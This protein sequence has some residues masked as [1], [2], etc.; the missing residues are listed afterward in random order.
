MRLL[1]A[2]YKPF[3]AL[4]NALTAEGCHLLRWIPGSRPLPAPNVDGV[5]VDFCAAARNLVAT[6]GLRRLVGDGVPII[7]INRDAPWHKGVRRRRLWGLRQLRLL[8]IYAS[9]SMQEAVRFAPRQLYLPNAAQ[10]EVYNL[11]ESTLEELRD[12]SRYR[13]PVTFL[14]NLD[15]QRYREHQPRV[16][17]LE[18]LR[19]R[20][21]GLGIALTLIHSME[22]S[23]AQ[24]AEVIRGSRINLNYG[25]ACDHGEQRTWGL[26]ERCYGIPAGGGFLLSDERCH[27]RDDFVPGVEWASFQGMEDCLTQVQFY[28][29]HFAESRRLA[30]AAHHRVWRDHTYAHRAQRLLA[31]LQG[32]HDDRLS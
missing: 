3:A 31:T 23:P 27:A 1:I 11:G 25:G 22:M 15:A 26:P 2:F 7:G 20:L 13:Y 12:L 5:L 14:G 24:Q 17:F 32:W 18:L 30:E 16:H 19:Q 8:D 21:S 28:L 6:W 9:H 29:D 10:V 4:E